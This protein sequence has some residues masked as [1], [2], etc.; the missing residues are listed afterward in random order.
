[1]I[2]KCK[3]AEKLKILKKPT[4]VLKTGKNADWSG[5]VGHGLV[6]HALQLESLRDLGIVALTR[7]P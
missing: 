6:G 1:M 4:S 2:S 5:L 7:P 3:D